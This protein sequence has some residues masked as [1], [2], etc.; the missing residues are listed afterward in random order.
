LA[1]QTPNSNPKSLKLLLSSNAALLGI[2]QSSLSSHVKNLLL[3]HLQSFFRPACH[4]Q[5]GLVEGPRGLIR[6]CGMAGHNM[7]PESSH[8]NARQI[9]AAA[10]IQ[11]IARLL[12][13]LQY[14]PEAA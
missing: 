9:H 11:N 8:L 14:H 6:D 12:A 10:I 3:R 7:T 5:R 1:I 4:A 13:T 2:L